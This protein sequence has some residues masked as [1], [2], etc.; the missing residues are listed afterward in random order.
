MGIQER[1]RILRERQRISRIRREHPEWY[2]ATGFHWLDPGPHDFWKEAF[3][4]CGYDPKDG[5]YVLFDQTRGTR[6]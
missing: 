6:T 2:R 1:V 4:G 5:Q 3:R